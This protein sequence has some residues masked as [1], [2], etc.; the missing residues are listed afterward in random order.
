MFHKHVLFSF[1]SVAVMVSK[2][3]ISEDITFDDSNLN[4]TA[5]TKFTCYEVTSIGFQSQ[6][7][8]INQFYASHVT[9]KL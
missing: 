5:S 6:G 4:H 1:S 7:Y 2:F 8:R 9:V 3:K